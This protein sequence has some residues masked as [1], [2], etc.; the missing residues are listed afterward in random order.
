SGKKPERPEPGKIKEE[1]K[2]GI[3]KPGK[4]KDAAQAN[5]TDDKS[6]PNISI[7]H[8][9]GTIA[10]RVD[11]RTGGVVS[12]FSPEDLLAMFPELKEIANIKTRLVFS[13]FSEDMR[14]AHHQILAREIA[15]GIESG[16]DGII[17][18]HGT[19]TMHYTAAALAFMLQNLPVPVILV[20]A[21]RSSDR[22]ST[23]AAQ[24]LLSAAYFIAHSDF[25]GV[26]IC[27]HENT[28]DNS[29]L[30]LPAAKS[31]K[32]HASRRD[33]FRPINSLLWARVNYAKKKIE[34]LKN[35]YPRKDKKRKILMK[36]KMEE[37]V[38]LIK[39][40]PN[41]DSSLIDFFSKKKYKGLVLE[42]TGLGHAPKNIFIS[43]KK[44]VKSGMVVC[45]ASQTIY[46]RVDMNIYSTGR[47][48]LK[49][50]AIPCG[51]M[52]PETAFIKLAWLLGNFGKNAGKTKEMMEKNI[53]GEISDRTEAGEFLN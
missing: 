10:S 19:D 1:E 40:S 5:M 52:L 29:C 24:N 41:F 43:L 45:M 4:R 18:T 47:D 46:G 3:E 42:G 9:G 6:K 39:I 12:S 2:F 20:G 28:D 22:G 48:L 30:I 51:D 7:L 38:A 31:R 16:A 37:K 26:A 14:F 23:D 15:K 21:Q 44:A 34:F 50:G 35:D 32:M 49:I 33:A 53:C 27:M 8:T 17:I 36:T 13:M 25:S 11:Y